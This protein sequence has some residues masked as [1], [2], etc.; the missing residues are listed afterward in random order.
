MVVYLEW[1]KQNMK[2]YRFG[3]SNFA[4]K[5]CQIHKYY[6][7]QKNSINTSINWLSLWCPPPYIFDCIV[8]DR[9][10]V[11]VIRSTYASTWGAVLLSE[12]LIL[13]SISL[14]WFD[15]ACY[16]HLSW[17]DCFRMGTGFHGDTKKPSR[18]WG[19]VKTSPTERFVVLAVWGTVTGLSS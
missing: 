4:I 1:E 7:I 8:S 6:K 13:R 3:R 2:H 15:F 16:Y 19:C 9:H 14:L 11:T 10:V 17:L 18:V 12:D 5:I